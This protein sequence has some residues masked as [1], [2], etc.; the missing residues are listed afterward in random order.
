MTTDDSPRP[1]GARRASAGI[2]AALFFAT[3]AFASLSV[4]GKLAMSPPHDVS[5]AALAMAR[6]LG[7]AVVFAGAHLALRTPRVTQLAD[8]LH[9]AVLAFFGVVCNQALLLVGLRITSA[10]SATLL[11]AMIPVFT[12]ALAAL[13][14]RER[15]SQ[16]AGAGTAV[17]L[18]G[19]AMLT[20]FAVPR[21]GDSF[22]LVYALST[23]IY[24]LHAK[25]ALERLGTVTVMAWVFGWGALLFAPVGGV[26]LVREAPS[27][28]L[29][30]A[31]LVAF[32]VLVPTVLAYA[33]NAWAL[34][35]A[36]PTLVAIYVFLRPPLAALLAWAQLGEALGA[37]TAVA[38]LVLLA[39]VTI[40][41]TAP[42]PHAGPAAR[43]APPARDGDALA[44]APGMALLSG[45][46]GAEV[47][48]PEPARSPPFKA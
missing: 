4:E 28:S 25:S 9:L 21:L 5:P 7:G 2:H 33:V 42:R 39:G 43:P 10:V 30:A 15:F 29:P 26:A 23:A 17:A 11:I 20:G 16:R 46:P 6:F 38:G 3:L 36:S 47:P 12:A 8:A 18:F 48:S 1:P 22:A 19:A 37:R 14:G 45:S 44:P 31:L 40:V 35:R 24:V 13:T 41:A 34:R 32:C 27:W